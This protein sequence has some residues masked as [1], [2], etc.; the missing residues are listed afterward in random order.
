VV[1]ALTASELDVVGEKAYT[2]ALVNR[3]R[4][5]RWAEIASAARTL[6]VQSDCRQTLLLQVAFKCQEASPTLNLL[7]HYWCY[8]WRVEFKPNMSKNRRF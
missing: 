3:D 8:G 1:A 5:T 6:A 7:W 4:R 2:T